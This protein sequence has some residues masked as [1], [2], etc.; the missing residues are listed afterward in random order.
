MFHICILSLPVKRLFGADNDC[1]VDIYI[2]YT[3]F[4]AAGQVSLFCLSHMEVT[5]RL[6]LR[7]CKVQIQRMCKTIPHPLRGMPP[8]HKGAYTKPKPPLC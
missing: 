7:F 8:L 5:L 2:Y 6:P 1:I 3:I 4:F